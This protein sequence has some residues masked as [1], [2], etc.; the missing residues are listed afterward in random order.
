MIF[1]R[2]DLGPKF[3]L[4]HYNRVKALIKYLGLKEYKIIV[5]KLYNSEFLEDEKKNIISLYKKNSFINELNDT[6]LFLKV[7]QSEK[8]SSIIVK[9][10][11]RLGY[12]WEKI[13]RKQS[14][15]LIVIDDNLEIKHY[16]DFYINHNP[17]FLNIS[18]NDL[19]T[20]KILNKKNCN[21]LLGP[22]FSLFNSDIIKN[23]KKNSD[24]VFYNGGSGNVLIYEKIIKS[25]LKKR[26]NNYQIILI[27]GPYAKN[28]K[29]IV[30]KYKKYKNI[31]IAYQPKN[32]LKYLRSTKV[33][34]SSA[35]ISIF[36]SS[37][38]KLPTLLFKMNKN[39]NLSDIDYEKLGHYFSLEKKEIKKT[40]KIVNLI[41]SM[42]KN[43]GQIKN[44]MSSSNIK[45][46]NIKENYIKNLKNEI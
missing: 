46:K 38:L 25:F 34:V 22:D 33:F 24:I 9:D 14:K 21:F 18:E 28:Y 3:G 16:A 45:V 8:K 5:D 42:L 2:I 35:G 39:Q 19:K 13:I 36:E 4:G 11:Y 12:R 43:L 31:Y 23:E 27:I 44:M 26:K 32:I 20:L 10:S 1:F 37:Y 40:D 29:E 6:K 30:K 41:N 7:V 17:R 15:K